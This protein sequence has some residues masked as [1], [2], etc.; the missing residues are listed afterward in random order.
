MKISVFGLGYVG[1]VATGCL[2]TLGHN[3][4]GVDVNESKVRLLNE[5]KS[6]IVENQISEILAEQY[7]RGNVS[8]TLDACRA[9]QETDVSFLCVGT[10]PSPQG[11]LSI[12]ALFK[13]A[14]QIGEA[15]VHKTTF[16]VIAIRSTVPPGTASK[17]A[18][19]IAGIS[20]RVPDSDFAI[21]ANPEFLREGTAVKDF[22]QPSYTV[23]ASSSSRATAIMRE[24][25]KDIPAPLIVT[26][27]SVAEMIKY[28]SN[29]FHA[30]KVVFANEVGNICS[31]IGVDSHE[32]MRIFCMD[33]KLNLSSYY[34][35]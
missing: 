14:R 32:L 34:L 15:L 12:D 22:F 26:T 31:H 20:G 9:V 35:R 23:I 29:A 19:S 18:E 11:H 30:L 28:V 7:T 33:T 27:V 21:V 17:L 6:P 8:A 3:I 25:Y 24:L 10:P 1:T 13:V 4:I 2:A 16:H 5:G